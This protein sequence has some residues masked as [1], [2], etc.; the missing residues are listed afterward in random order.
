MPPTAILLDNADDFRVE[1]TETDGVL[2]GVRVYRIADAGTIEEALTAQGLPTRGTA[3]SDDYS[4]LKAFNLT[5]ERE[6]GRR[7]FKVTVRY[8]QD[9]AEV[10]T[11]TDGFKA[12]TEIIASEI[13]QQAQFAIDGRRLTNDGSGVALMATAIGFEVSE[14]HQALPQIADLLSLCTPFP[15]VNDQLVTLPN[16][17]ASGSDIDVPTGQLLYRSFALGRDGDLF[18]VRHRLLRAESWKT[19][20]FDLNASGEGE[21]VTDDLEPYATSSFPSFT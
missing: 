4:T 8:R 9:T 12:T 17:L 14:Y 7:W 16:V 11:P 10:F 5:P 3:W 2:A 21:S 15:T 13:S 6:P 18:V 1:L 20:R 19:A